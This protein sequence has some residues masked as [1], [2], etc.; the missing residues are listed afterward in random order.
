MNS[1]PIRHTSPGDYGRWCPVCKQSPFWDRLY[2]LCY[3]I[4]CTAA[5]NVPYAARVAQLRFQKTPFN[6]K[7]RTAMAVASFVVQC[8]ALYYF[9]QR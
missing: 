3:N 8:I 6:A 2:G 1:C 5:W 9:M 7:L 4:D